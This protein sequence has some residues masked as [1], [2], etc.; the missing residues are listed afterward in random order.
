MPTC[1]MT[2]LCSCKNY[3]VILRDTLPRWVR[4]AASPSRFDGDCFGEHILHRFDL[5]RMATSMLPS[6][7]GFIGLGLMG[8]PMARNLAQKLPQGAE[9]FIYDISEKAMQSLETGDATQNYT[10]KIKR[11]SSPSD[12]ASRAVGR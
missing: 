8:L 5:E 12:V 2:S 9:L 10:A 7:V 11:C 1:D 6:Q 3:F 4:C